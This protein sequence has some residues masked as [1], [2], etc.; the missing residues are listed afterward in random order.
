MVLSL[1]WHTFRRS[2]EGAV[3]VLGRHEAAQTQPPH[4]EEIWRVPV[5]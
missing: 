2:R 1:G 3:N 4:P 5:R